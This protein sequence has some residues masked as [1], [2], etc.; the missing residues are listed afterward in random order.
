MFSFLNH[1]VTFY[2]I[3][4]IVYCD[5]LNHSD[6]IERS[7]FIRGYIHSLG[8][9]YPVER[10]VAP[11][12]KRIKA[13]FNTNNPINLYF[14]LFLWPANLLRSKMYMR[15]YQEDNMAPNNRDREPWEV[16]ADRYKEKHVQIAKYIPKYANS[17]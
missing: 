11:K 5:Y 9:R 10:Q 16:M 3:F 12:C 2:V 17:K 14:L 1:Y 13:Y 8:Y 7:N 4:S 15:K 6:L